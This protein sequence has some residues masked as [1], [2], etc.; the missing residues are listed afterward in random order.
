MVFD[1]DEFKHFHL[2]VQN[3][4]SSLGKFLGTCRNITL[5]CYGYLRLILLFDFIFRCM[6]K[7]HDFMFTI[8]FYWLENVLY[9]VLS[10][11]LGGFIRY[12]IG[13]LTCI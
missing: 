2:S 6:L 7:E 12:T 4:F 10:K 5:S 13:S 11:V 9:M 8:I 1:R 3:I